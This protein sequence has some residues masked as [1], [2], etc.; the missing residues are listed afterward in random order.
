M[1]ELDVSIYQRDYY[2]RWAMDPGPALNTNL[3]FEI[4]GNLN[5]ELFKKAIHEFVQHSENQR[6]YFVQKNNDIKQV[7]VDYAEV[8]INQ[9]NFRSLEMGEAEKK[10]DEA[11]QEIYEHVFDLHVLPLFRYDLISMPENKVIFVVT[12][13]HIISDAYVATYVVK[14]LSKIYNDLLM[15]VGPSLKMPPAIKDYIHFEKQHYAADKIAADIDFW[16]KELSGV[17]PKVHL[18]DMRASRSKSEVGGVG[19][20]S[21]RLDEITTSKLRQFARDNKVTPFLLM[22]AIWSLLLSR[23]SSQQ[24]VVLTYPIDVRPAG[25]KGLLGCFINTVPIKINVDENKSIAEYLQLIA[26]QRKKSKTHQRISLFEIARIMRGKHSNT[27]PKFNASIVVAHLGHMKLNLDGCTCKSIPSQVRNNPEDLALHY[28]ISD[29]IDMVISYSRELFDEES[30]SEFAKRLHGLVNKFISSSE[31]LL[32]SISIVTPRERDTMLYK[33]NN[34]SCDYAFR[35]TIH[36]LFEEQVKRS[37]ENIAVI[38]ENTRLSYNDIN[39]QAN[40]MARLIRSKYHEIYKQDLPADALIGLCVERSVDMLVSILAILKAGAAYLPLDPDYPQDRLEYMLE[41]SCASLLLIQQNVMCKHSRLQILQQDKYIIIDNEEIHSDQSRLSPDNLDQVNSANSLAYVMYTSGSTGRPKGVQIEHKSVVNR[42]N[43]MQSKYVLKEDD[44]VL[45]KTSFSFDVSVWEIMWPILFGGQLVVA[46]AGGQKDVE[47]LLEVIKQEDITRIHFV[48]AMLHTLIDYLETNNSSTSKLSTLRDIYC[49]GEVLSKRLATRTMS[50]LQARLH[51]LYGPTEACIDVTFYR[52]EE[53]EIQRARTV[54]IGQPIDNIRLYILDNYM[55]LLSPGMPGQLYIGGVGLGRGYINNSESTKDRF[56]LNPFARELGLEPTDRIYKTGDIVRW[57][58]S[59]KIEYLGRND[60]QTKIRGYRIE[61]GEVE[62][63]LC[64]HKTVVQACVVIRE[65]HHQKYLAAYYVLGKKNNDPGYT[66]LR[67]FLAKSMPGYMLPSVFVNLNEIPLTPNGKI[68]IKSLP[69]LDISSNEESY[70]APRNDLERRLCVIFADALQLD[71]VGIKDDFFGLG[72]NSILAV[73]LISRI[74]IELGV[75][76]NVLDFLDS[77]NIYNL[78]LCHSEPPVQVDILSLQNHM[79]L[80]YFEK[81]I[82]MHQLQTGNNIIYNESCL[83]DIYKKITIAEILTS[84]QYIM[85]KYEILNSNYR[86]EGGKFIRVINCNG[87]VT[88]EDITLDSE[89]MIQ[90]KLLHLASNPFNLQKDKLIRF[91]LI[92]TPKGQRIGMVAYHAIIDATSFVNILLPEFFRKLEDSGYD[93]NFS[94]QEV[95]DSVM[96]SRAISRHYSKNKDD[97]IEFWRRSI[98]DCEPIRISSKPMASMDFSGA[99]I[100][101]I[102]DKETTYALREVSSRLGV[103]LFCV[104]YSLFSLLMLRLS[105][106]KKIAIR[107]N[108]DERMFAPEYNNIVG[109]FIN[110][111]FIISNAS[112]EFSLSDYITQASIDIQRSIKNSVPFPDLLKLDNSL[113]LNLSDVH[114]NIEAEEINDLPYNQTQIYS[115]SGQVKQ[116]LYFELD[117]K[118]EE[119]YGRVEYKTAQYDLFLIESLVTSYKQLARTVQSNL[120]KNILTIPL[121]GIDTFKQTLME[122]NDTYVPYPK[123]KTIYQLFEEQASKTP[124]SIAVVFDQKRLTYSELNK[125]ANQLS[126]LIRVKYKSCTKFDIKPDCLIGLCIER[127]LDLI[128]C[129]LGIL[130]AGAAYV[131]LDP[132]YP[133]DRLEYMIED[134]H[135]LL[136][137][138]QSSILNKVS[139]LSNKPHAGLLIIDNDDVIDD[140]KKQSQTDL[141]KISGSYDLAYVIYTSGSTGKPKGVMVEHDNLYASIFARMKIYKNNPTSYLLTSSIAFDSSVAGIFWVLSVGGQLVITSQSVLLDVDTLA[142]T[143]AHENVTHMLLVPSLYEVVLSRHHNLVSLE[144]VIVCGERCPLALLNLHNKHLPQTLLINEYGPTEATVWATHSVLTN[145]VTIGKPIINYRVYILDNN[146]NPCPIGAQ[147]ELHI[148]GPGVARGYLGQLELTK[149]HFIINPHAKDLGLPE[150]DIIYKTGDRVRWLPDGNIEYLG[151]NDSQVKVRGFRVELGEIEKCLCKHKAI[152]QACVLDIEKNGNKYLVVYYVCCKDM[153]DVE[154]EALRSYLLQFLPDYMIPQSFMKLDKMPLS[155]NGKINKHALRS[156]EINFIGEKYVAP[157]NDVEKKLADIWSKILNT[158]KAGVSD[159]FFK[160]G[161]TSL[162]IIHLVTSLNK[163][164]GVSVPV[165]WAFRNPTIAMQAVSIRNDYKMLK[166]ITPVITIKELSGSFPLFLVHPAFLGGEIYLRM[167][168]YFNDDSGLL[169]NIYAIESYNLAR[170]AT[171]VTSIEELARIY[172]RSIKEM[173]PH[174]PYFIGGW[175]FGC[176][177]AYEIIQQL[178]ASGDVVLSLYMLAPSDMKTPKYSAKVQS[179]VDTLLR[180]AKH[181]PD[182]KVSKLIISFLKYLGASD[183]QIE[184][185]K[186]MMLIEDKMQNDYQLLPND[187]IDAVLIS[188]TKMSHTDFLSVKN[189]AV[190]QKLFALTR[191]PYDGFSRYMPQIKQHKLESDHYSIMHVPTL[192]EQTVAIIVSDMQC[193]IRA[194]KSKSS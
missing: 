137:I 163:A 8:R 99:L 182:D 50:L 69:D 23:Y 13:H 21:L 87:E 122:W 39:I 186:E 190:R 119:I 63:A 168:P 75:N 88:C 80:H 95:M 166:Q 126:R 67:D 101:F 115:H 14:T 91:Y 70:V 104:I 173:H 97:K 46:K 181:I 192:I 184:I 49:S 155:P 30:I 82:L 15:G 159:N 94:K 124:N 146:L 1:Q 161:G 152:Y 57:L 58:A 105:G 93:C 92:N 29:C 109:C 16:E 175:S 180:S 183:E 26:R 113:I 188:S 134:S 108:L 145:R 193:K 194:W 106:N 37:P 116:G 139:F 151:R 86:L 118:D 162:L 110:N 143:I 5:L 90:A 141:D 61:L 130:K 85:S 20:H 185:A 96:L 2:M 167:A 140:L 157:R 129:I 62:C 32:H 40:Q 103:S 164:F 77:K 17:D 56:I 142:D 41:D 10:S 47:Y 72:G 81:M 102:V 78:V 121:L 59:G 48:P 18:F 55:K 42:I 172:I 150:S 107:T 52:C 12:F 35:L 191:L 27:D 76:Y 74:N 112:K 66:K 4:S 120:N 135:T 9:Y 84:A 111:I 170:I 132:D 73:N 68:D 156:H 178:Q 33:W 136:I 114:F 53:D 44:K 71:R 158:H 177:I 45:Q 31:Q 54:P 51:N 43:W 34:T 24:Q 148:G 36:Q 25:F 19:S 123:N 187:R 3:T 160:I 98:I 64:K 79:E 133:S 144:Y 38:F 165:S 131:P 60:Q 189:K 100:S 65:K 176:I 127:S 117:V 22:T 147:G 138:T 125:K 28:E 6:S 171:P 149:Q 179:Q 128:I 83:I 154:V 89:D 7:I 169:G 11:L 153:K 174:G